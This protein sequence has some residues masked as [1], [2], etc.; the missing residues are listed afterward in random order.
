MDALT[1]L[2]Y[3][4][5]IFDFLSMQEVF[6]HAD[7]LAIFVLRDEKFSA[8]KEQITTIRNS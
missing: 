4:F 7:L 1:V 2:T 5:S 3:T 6:L 8:G